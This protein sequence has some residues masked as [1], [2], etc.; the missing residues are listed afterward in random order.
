[1]KKN[2]TLGIILKAVLLMLVMYS[3]GFLVGNLF[4]RAT[5]DVD[6]RKLMKVDH[7]TAGLVLTVIHGIIVIGGLVSGYIMFF[8]ANKAARKWDGEDEDYIDRVEKSIDITNI[9]SSTELIFNTI[10]FS[11]AVYFMEKAT[12]SHFIPL[13]VI[14]LLGLTATLVLNERCINLAKQL[15][16][17]K[18][19]SAFDPKFYKKW[20]DSCDEAQKQLIWQAGFKA[21]RAANYAC[22]V[23]W[24]IAMLLQMVLHYG[25]IPMICIGVIWLWMNT[26]YVSYAYKL[27]HRS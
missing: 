7:Y 23:M 9:I 26:A 18:K 8:R 17:E 14:F 10:L 16:P 1:M 11:C 12:L 13:T 24:F 2:K 27:E 22:L 21:Y 5:D 19:G 20:M 3:S 15:N 6:F 4:G 25:L